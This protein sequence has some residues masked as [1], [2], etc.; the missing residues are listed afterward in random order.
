MVNFPVT[1]MQSNLKI[2]FYFYAMVVY[3]MD[4]FLLKNKMIRR[5]NS[6]DEDEAETTADLQNVVGEV[7]ADAG[8][9]ELIFRQLK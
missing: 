6:Q 1:T 7:V 5:T 8:L 4:E 9:P 3:K 2:R